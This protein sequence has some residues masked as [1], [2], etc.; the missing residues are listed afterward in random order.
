M[1]RLK[2]AAEQAKI[3]LSSL[4]STQV[5]V[6]FLAQKGGEPLSL[7]VELAARALRVADPGPGASRPSTP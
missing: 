1:T 4:E 7:E 5:L 3:E 2:A 6:P